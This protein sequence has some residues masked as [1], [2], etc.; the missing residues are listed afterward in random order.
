MIDMSLPRLDHATHIADQL[1]NLAAVVKTRSCASL[2]D[3]NRILETIS[4]RFFNALFGWELVNLNT[5]KANYPAADL[6][7]CGRRTRGRFRLCRVDQHVEKS[8][9][10]GRDWFMNPDHICMR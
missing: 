9:S 4:A 8:T 1:N 6:G 10:P 3:A 7:D 2:T 5:D